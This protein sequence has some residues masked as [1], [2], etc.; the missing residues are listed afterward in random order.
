MPAG[1]GVTA[2][3]GVRDEGVYL[4]TGGLGGIGITLAEQLA[5]QV[6]ARLVL[7]SRTGLPPR[8]EW[9]GLIAA[10]G[11]TSRAGRG[12]AAI[13]RMERAGAE[14]LVLAADVASTA[15][16]RELRERVLA[17]FGRIDG[18]VHAAGVPGGGMA[19]VKERVAAEAVLAPK[20]AGTLALE[21]AFSDLDLDF[22]VLCSSVIAL[23]GGFGQVDYC[24][25]NNFLDAYA[26]S[27]HRWR[28]PVTSVN[29]GGWQEV[30]M[31]AEVA[32]PAAF[33]AL[34]RGNVM[35]PVDHPLITARYDGDGDVLGWCSGT[36][37]ASTHWVLD[38][39]RIGGVPVLPGT[40]L[41]EAVRCAAQAVAPRPG[42]V[43]E[44]RD[45]AFIEPLSVPDGV[46]A[47]LRVAFTPDA[48]GLSFEVTSMTRGAFR[49]HAQ[50]SVGWLDEPPARQADLAAIAERCALGTWEHGDSGI[51]ASGL[52]TFGPRWGN[53]R[54][55][56]LGQGEELAL[57]EATS[58]T[59]S[60]VD[61]ANQWVLHPALL[62]EGTAFG[63]TPAEYSYLPLGYGRIAIS[64]GLPA[65]LWSHLRF[66]DNDGAEVVVADLAMFDDD[67]RE[68]VSI[69]DF[70]LRRIDPAALAAG[71]AAGTDAEAGRRG[72]GRA[73]G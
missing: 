66:H 62:D 65:R 22:V 57:L 47:E 28:A 43:I 56:H 46:S 53:L 48:D 67:G 6:R 8:D 20:V 51:S 38:D 27:G 61:H 12:V 69:S 31:A 14:V 40:G 60:D 58:Q 10:E 21:A 37:S 54:R 1:L 13:R 42:R 73:S 24:A 19:E 15:A 52:I 41:L 25:A 70:T 72:R 55:V 44:L 16:M 50:G 36:I 11:P 7:I 3:P 68:V 17:R 18:I 35:T 71:L 49:T 30:G 39:H 9:D 5:R 59:S 33:R 34:Q 29:W 26:A 23:V 64:A 32:A 4:I 63:H 45:V 2:G